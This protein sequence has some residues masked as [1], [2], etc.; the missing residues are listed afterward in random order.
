M[1]YVVL[2]VCNTQITGEYGI[3]W[4]DT[5]SQVESPLSPHNS[6]APASL[7][8]GVAKALQGLH[9]EEQA[10]LLIEEV[11]FPLFFGILVSHNHVHPALYISLIEPF[12]RLRDQEVLEARRPLE[13][14]VPPPPHHNP[15]TPSLSPQVLSLCIYFYNLFGLCRS[16]RGFWM[17]IW[18]GK[19]LNVNHIR[20]WVPQA[21]AAERVGLQPAEQEA[22]LRLQPQL[23]PQQVLARQK[24][25]RRTSLKFVKQLDTQC[26]K[27]M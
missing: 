16:W 17:E 2:Q 11:I 3:K 27:P 12:S 26:Q 5:D 13:E 8:Q 4:L 10:G 6:S 18:R 14:K 20:T 22:G 25:S 15:H 1:W 9:L 7:S 23:E 19:Y 24:T 21:R